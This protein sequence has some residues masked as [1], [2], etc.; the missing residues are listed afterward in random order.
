MVFI[1]VVFCYLVVPVV[2]SAVVVSL[3]QR[4]LCS[5]VLE[6]VE[7]WFSVSEVDGIECTAQRWIRRT[8]V[9]LI[10]KYF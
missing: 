2:I 7:G 3:L 5:N 10:V 1:V 6:V 4:F 8:L 9:V